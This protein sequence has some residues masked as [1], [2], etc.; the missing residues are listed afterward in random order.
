MTTNDANSILMGGSNAPKWKFDQPGDT[1]KGVITSP[2]EAVQEREYDPTNPG[3]GAPKYFP[4]GDPIMGINVEVQTNNTF[5]DDDGLR[6]FYIQGKR[7]K[8]AVRNAVRESGARGLEVGGELTVTLTSYVM[9]GDRRSGINWDITYTPAAQV[10]LMKPAPTPQPVVA[11]VATPAAGP[12]EDTSAQ[13]AAFEAWQK[14]Q[15]ARQ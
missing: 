10:A 2:P 6:T 1:D 11:P 3:G 9:P 5:G 4:S 7:L 13:L 14:S 8:D 12:V 15:A